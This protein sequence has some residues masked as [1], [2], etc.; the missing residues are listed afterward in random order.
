M[1]PRLIFAIISTLLEEAAL[2][3]V[4]LWALPQIDINIPVA[5]LIALMVAWGTYSTIIYR[6]GSQ[7]LRRK[8]MIALPDMV[9]SHGKVVSPL[10]PEGL[11]NIRGELWIAKSAG[12]E[13][14]PG[15][16]VIVLEQNSLKLVVGDRSTTNDTAETQ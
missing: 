4:V 2:A 12:E 5:G 7:A 13:I 11:V 14:K 6:I 1:T 3:A 8:P 9:G 16:Q 15:S 10:I